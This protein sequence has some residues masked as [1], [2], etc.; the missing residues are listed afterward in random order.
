L[1]VKQV[2]EEVFHVVRRH[3]LGRVGREKL[4]EAVD[5]L[6]VET[7]VFGFCA[8]LYAVIKREREA[9]LKGFVIGFIKV[10]VTVDFVSHSLSSIG[11]FER[12]VNYFRLFSI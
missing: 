9:Y 12:K 10:F 5:N 6:A 3:L 11:Y 4:F 2:S 8:F 7:A 1:G